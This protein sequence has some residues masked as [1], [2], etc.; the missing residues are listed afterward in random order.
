MFAENKGRGK[1][2]LH[3]YGPDLICSGKDEIPTLSDL[4]AK[5]V[6]YCCNTN[7]IQPTLAVSC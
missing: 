6:G 2:G 3:G 7:Q 1:Q 5:E 4:L